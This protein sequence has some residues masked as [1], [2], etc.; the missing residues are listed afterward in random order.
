MVRKFW[1]RRFCSAWPICADK[2]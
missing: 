2:I 1:H